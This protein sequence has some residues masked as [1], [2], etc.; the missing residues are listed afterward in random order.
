MGHMTGHMAPGVAACLQMMQGMGEHHPAKRHMLQ[1]TRL[2]VNKGRPCR[3]RAHGFEVTP[4]AAAGRPPCPS[5]RRKGLRRRSDVGVLR[6]VSGRCS[7][8][9]CAERQGRTETE[10]KAPR[11]RRP[12]AVGGRPGRLAA[13]I[14]EAARRWA[15]RKERGGAGGAGRRR[16]TSPPSRPPARLHARLSLQGCSKAYTHGGGRTA[17]G[18]APR[19]TRACCKH[20]SSPAGLPKDSCKG[21]WCDGE[22]GAQRKKGRRDAT[23][24]AHRGVV[25]QA[26][27]APFRHGR[28]RGGTSAVLNTQARAH[29]RTH[30]HAGWLRSNSPPPPPPL[31]WF[32]RASTLFVPL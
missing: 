16:R 28:A 5:R 32:V 4:A 26:R 8:T 1:Q 3:A 18:R 12:L 29:T 10:G 30:I 22:R 23:R 17:E 9:T 20:G 11:V 21:S 14:W 2:E 19:H 24:R 25:Q 31:C 13:D 15:A 7:G 6:C 27:H